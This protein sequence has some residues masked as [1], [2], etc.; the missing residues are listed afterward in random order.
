[1]LHTIGV[2]GSNVLLKKDRV[3]FDKLV[4]SKC[5]RRRW[6]TLQLTLYWFTSYELFAFQ[7]LLR[8]ACKLCS[9]ELHCSTTRPVVGIPV[10]LDLH[11]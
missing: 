8:F 7:M 4:Y 1:M 9:L 10:N 2:G 6:C 5:W 11:E 3:P